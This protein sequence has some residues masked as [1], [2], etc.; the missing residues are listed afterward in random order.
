MLQALIVQNSLIQMFTLNMSVYSVY[1]IAHVRGLLQ[2]G[3]TVRWT[4]LFENC[5]LPPII[6][7]GFFLHIQVF[8]SL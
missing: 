6:V 3:S 2:G 1:F 5:F 8:L 4:F 7:F